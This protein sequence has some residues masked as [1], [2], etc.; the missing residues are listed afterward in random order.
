M[1]RTAPAS[2]LLLV[3]GCTLRGSDEF[4]AEHRGPCRRVCLVCRDS[5]P[6]RNE[7]DSDSYGEQQPGGN[8]SCSRSGANLFCLPAP[9]LFVLVAQRVGNHQRPKISKI[10][11]TLCGTHVLE[12]T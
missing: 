3:A 6:S 5:H 7:R 10:M 11:T 12:R 8:P 2:V 4:C 1:M 9:R